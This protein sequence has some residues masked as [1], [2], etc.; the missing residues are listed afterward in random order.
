MKLT[1]N[2]LRFYAA[3][4]DECRYLAEDFNNVTRYYSIDLRVDEHAEVYVNTK[5]K[6]VAV[7]GSYTDFTPGGYEDYTNYT[8]QIPFGFIEDPI[9]WQDE[10]EEEKHQKLLDKIKA[11]ADA[12]REKAAWVERLELQE[13]ARL[14]GKYE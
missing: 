10:W 9:A 8:I 13:L 11:K 2:R 7:E 12:E 1:P 6:Y 3:I 5:K 4:A 14:K